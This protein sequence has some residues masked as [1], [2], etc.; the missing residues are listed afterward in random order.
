MSLYTFIFGD[1]NEKHIRRYRKYIEIIKQI[2]AVQEKEITTLEQVKAK[3]AEFQSKF[4]G[5]DPKK[6]EDLK[7][8]KEILEEIKLEALALHRTACRL[9]K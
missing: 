2:E 4:V 8:I 6:E 1:I 7:R 3:T 5:L 9:I